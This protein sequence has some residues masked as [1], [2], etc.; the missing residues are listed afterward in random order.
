MVMNNA[1]IIL[2]CM[3]F[4]FDIIKAS[5]SF[6]GDFNYTRHRR[7]L[8]YSECSLPTFPENGDWKLLSGTGKPGE[9]VPKGTVIQFHCNNGYKLSMQSP[10]V[11][12][13]GIW[14]S[15]PI[16][17]KLCPP[18]YPSS[19]YSLKCIDSMG[20]PI[21]CT[22][23]T[24]GT[25]LQFNCAPF[26]ES[27]VGSKSRLCRDGSWNY[28][29]P[30]CLPVCGQ[31]I[32]ETAKPLIF[33]AKPNEKLQYP[34]VTAIYQKINSS[35]VNICGGS[36]LSLKISKIIVHEDYKGEN[37]RF[38]ADIAVLV[39]KVEFQ[40]NEVIQPVCFN[41]LNSIYLHVGSEGEVS[42]WG[43]AECGV[44]SDVLR[45]LKI[46]YK[47][48]TTCAAEL[49]AAFADKYNMGDKICT[50][51]YN[52]STSVCEG[53]SGNGLTFKNPDN[54]RY[55]IHGV[56]SLGPRSEQHCDIQQNSLYTKVVQYYEFVDRILT[57]Y[58]SEEKSCILPPHPQ[59]GEWIISMK[60][61]S[62]G[63]A[64][65]SSTTLNIRCNVGFKLSS[66]TTN[67]ECA[68]AQ[69]MPTCQLLCPPPNF[70]KG[71]NYQCTNR[72]R[73]AINCLDAVD[74]STLS[75]FCPKGFEIPKGTTNTKTCIKGS[76]GSSQLE[77]L[78]K[79]VKN[80][81]KRV[82]ISNDQG[83]EYPWNVGVYKKGSYMYICGGSLI[84]H[85]L[86]L[87]AA[88]CV[89]DK[90]RY[91]VLPIENFVIAAGK[92]SPIYNF[93][94]TG[95]QYSEIS[96]IQVHDHY[97]RDKKYLAD[98]AILVATKTFTFNNF[99]QPVCFKDVNSIQLQPGDEGVIW[100]WD[101]QKT[102]VCFYFHKIVAG[103][104]QLQD[105]C[106][107]AV[108]PVHQLDTICGVFH[109]AARTDPGTGFV[110]K[111]PEDER[112]YVHGVVSVNPNSST[113]NFLA[114]NVSFYYDFI[115]DRLSKYQ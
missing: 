96:D 26:Y 32:G 75:Y 54:N 34:W 115:D 12:C 29:K 84:S 105:T 28:P 61:K 64:V 76:W 21:S 113:Q 25:Y 88:Y 33:G 6:L 42:G 3:L 31:K 108:T 22:E 114:T 79:P 66:T 2:E 80:C 18:V 16:C 5:N 58:M 100:G 38:L 60:G 71:T 35:Y 95:A 30:I 10:Y 36:I 43:L 53:D 20:M 44:P 39:V 101:V 111:D 94:D 65:P 9:K 109:N 57:R 110:I 62:P 98:F 70:L 92:K 52:Q 46:P 23:A 85:K 14:N 50:G 7:Q 63:D 89:T 1:I 82:N 83:L 90:S 97:G 104:Y 69:M 4:S 78:P 27:Q 106:A 24:E 73:Q 19:T 99:V 72:E 17:Q 86:V 91:T 112:Y 68:S 59:N 74:G 56:V 37:R 87:T 93:K 11:V 51:L 41:N 15:F 107:Q 13:D 8:G 49:P 47:S 102:T 67:I 77:C 103:T 55:Y 81:G 48:E 40:I 45:T